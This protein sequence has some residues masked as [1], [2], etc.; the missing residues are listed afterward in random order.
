MVVTT[1]IR[2]LT[3]YK[4]EKT[5]ELNELI[6]K[7]ARGLRKSFVG[8]WGPET[9]MNF[10]VFI[11]QF[12]RFSRI[13]KTAKIKIISGSSINLIVLQGNIPCRSGCIF[14]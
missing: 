7:Y 13:L 4:H 11:C 9:T 5:L 12:S 1:S 14:S 6:T 8:Q 2:Y 10:S 3:N